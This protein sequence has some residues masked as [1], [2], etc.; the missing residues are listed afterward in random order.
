MAD[1]SESTFDFYL[2]KPSSELRRDQAC[3]ESRRTA[4][5]G[6]YK[7]NRLGLYDM[8]GN[9][10]AYLCMVRNRG[11]MPRCFHT[12]GIANLLVLSASICYNTIV[13]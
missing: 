11:L 9:V 6:T 13:G 5:V 12:K 4:P 1:R 7:P 3:M 10:Q 8:Y 2:E